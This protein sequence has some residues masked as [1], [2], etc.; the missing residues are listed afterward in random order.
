[1]ATV[2][3]ANEL[4]HGLGHVSRLLTIGRALADRGHR[5]VLAVPDLMAPLALLR[6]AGIPVLQSP[7]P[8]RVPGREAVGAIATSYADILAWYRYDEP[9]ALF[10][11]VTAWQRLFDHEEAALVIAD[12]APAA[13]IAASHTIP[14]VI[15]GNGLTVP[16]T[17]ADTFPPFRTDT[18]SANRDAA[19]AASIAAVQTRRGRPAAATL[20][21]ALRGS[22]RFACCFPELDPARAWRRQPA[23]GPLGASPGTYADPEEP[24]FFAYLDGSSP[25]LETLLLGLVE[26]GDRG[27][28]YVRGAPRFLKSLLRGTRVALHESPP[29]PSEVLPSASVVLFRI[30]AALGEQ[31]H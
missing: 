30:G 18:P 6:D 22:A 23:T 14:T 1:M 17:D 25:Q 21:E 26:S 8:H 13:C 5:L 7:V 15:V 24:R 27:S 2:F 9:D 31:T 10:T 12:H 16:P 4:G 11:L 20:T 29:S 3:L 28:V 19:I